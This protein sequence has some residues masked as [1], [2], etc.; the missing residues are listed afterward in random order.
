MMPLPTLSQGFRHSL[1]KLSHGVGSAGLMSAA[2]IPGAATDHD[3]CR[4]SFGYRAAASRRGI[5]HD[6]ARGHVGRRTPHPGSSS[7]EASGTES[8][9]VSKEG[10]EGEELE[11]AEVAPLL[12]FDGPYA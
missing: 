12:R 4:L 2:F 9:E 7:Q 8:R 1:L 5:C 3:C 11:S 10:E 6:H